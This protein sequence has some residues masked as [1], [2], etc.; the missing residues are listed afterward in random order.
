M[1]I[2]IERSAR[3]GWSLSEVNDR[4]ARSGSS[5]SEVNDRSARSGRPLSEVNDRSARSGC[6]LSKV[7]EHQGRSGCSLSKVNEHQERSGW[8]LSAVNEHSARS[9]RSLS[10]VNGLGERSERSFTTSELERKL[11]PLD[12]LAIPWDVEVFGMAKLR[13]I[14]TVGAWMAACVATSALTPLGCGAAQ[15]DYSIV[16]PGQ[17]ILAPGPENTWQ[18]PEAIVAD[19]RGCVKEHARDLKTYSH[20]TK[21]DLRDPQFVSTTR[22]GLKR[23]F[24]NS[25]RSFVPAQRPGLKPGAIP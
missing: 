8:T 18:P 24:P 3:S 4:S 6:S 19:L 9:G 21:F 2:R 17:T 12:V 16:S 15:E 13:S 11:V 22:P 1:Q 25:R 20:H 10:E 14:R 5:L 7:N 23:S